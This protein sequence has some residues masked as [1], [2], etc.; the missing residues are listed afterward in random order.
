MTSFRGGLLC[1]VLN[2]EGTCL[3]FNGF[4]LKGLT[5]ANRSCSISS[6]D[7]DIGFEA[8]ISLDRRTKDG[9]PAATFCGSLFLTGLSLGATD[10][11]LG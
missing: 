1:V 5:W 11:R 8:D 4:A 10:C 3:P 7:F 6:V 9:V 2:L